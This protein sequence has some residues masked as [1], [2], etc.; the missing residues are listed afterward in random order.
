MDSGHFYGK[1]FHYLELSATSNRLLGVAAHIGLAIGAILIAMPP[2]RWLLRNIVYQPGQGPTRES[3]KN[4]IVHYRAIATAD[5]PEKNRV[6]GMMRWKGTSMYHLTAV[7]L[8]EAAAVLLRDDGVT[9]RKLGG[10][11]LTPATLGQA[12][13]D[14]LMKAGVVIEA[15]MMD[16]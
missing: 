11:L 1:N 5:C 8:V 3:T 4:D 16:D 14:R 7:Y 6:F 15:H 2:V 9:E 13:I 10:G 12:Y